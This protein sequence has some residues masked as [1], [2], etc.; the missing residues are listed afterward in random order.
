MSLRKWIVELLG[1][2]VLPPLISPTRVVIASNNYVERE[3]LIAVLDR[4]LGQNAVVRGVRLE[5]SEKSGEITVK[6]NVDAS[7]LEGAL[8]YASYNPSQPQGTASLGPDG[9]VSVNPPSYVAKRLK[10]DDL[11][12]RP[13]D[14]RYRLIDS[15]PSVTSVYQVDSFPTGPTPAARLFWLYKD[16]ERLQGYTR[17]RN[18]V[19]RAKQLVERD[20]AAPKYVSCDFPDKGLVRRLPSADTGPEARAAWLAKNIP[21]IFAPG[22]QFGVEPTKAGDGFSVTRNGA[23]WASPFQLQRAANAYRDALQAHVREA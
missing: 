6:L 7:G 1:G 8:P 20:N 10:L 12:P 16:G 15:F 5:P 13:L 19:A 22:T 4:A 11:P 3:P 18:A 9:I 14:R 2:V 23:V 17:R 21:S